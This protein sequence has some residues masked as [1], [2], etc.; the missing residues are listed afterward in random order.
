M[1]LNGKLRLAKPEDVEE[2]SG[3]VF[4]AAGD[5]PNGPKP[6]RDKIKET[7][8][9][10]IS[11]DVKV[12]IVILYEVD[13]AIVGFIVGIVNP[14]VFSGITQ[15]AELGYYVLPEY[16]SYKVYVELLD[17]Y[18][19]WAKEIV[20]ADLISVATY[21]PRFGKVYERK[22]YRLTETSYMKEL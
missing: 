15:V 1:V 3:V 7:L 6:D 12:S 10:L 22:G 14:N 17:T 13:E 20:S 8:K 11:S 9:H 21:N 5:I 18:E 16:S 2:L 4:T 19:S